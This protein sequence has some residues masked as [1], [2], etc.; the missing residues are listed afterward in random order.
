G[1]QDGADAHPDGREVDVRPQAAIGL[2]EGRL[3]RGVGE[4]HR[5]IPRHQ[6]APAGRRMAA[7]FPR[8]ITPTTGA[9]RYA[10]ASCGR[11]ID[12]RKYSSIKTSTTP[13]SSPSPAA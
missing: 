8:G 5:G 2:G 9:P 4:D 7:A 13:S 11:V 10:S 6:G 3:Q 12:R 1:D